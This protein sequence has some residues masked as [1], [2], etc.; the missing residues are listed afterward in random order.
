[1]E[2]LYSSE[3]CCF[4]SS[5]VKRAKKWIPYRLKLGEEDEKMY[6]KNVEPATE[7]NCTYIQ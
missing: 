7:P 4:S 5:W 6:M 3:F 1:M 2:I